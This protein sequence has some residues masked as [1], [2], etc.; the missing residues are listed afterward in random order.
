MSYIFLVNRSV[1][2]HQDVDCKIVDTLLKKD[3]GSHTDGWDES[4]KVWSHVVLHLSHTEG[5]F[6]VTCNDVTKVIRDL[7]LMFVDR[8]RELKRVNEMVSV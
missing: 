5:G 8:K 2:Q 4:D 1:L 3:T 7:K 6:G